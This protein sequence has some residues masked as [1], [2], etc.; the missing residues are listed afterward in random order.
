V[1]LL[2]TVD[3]VFTVSSRGTVVL[4][5][6]L[7]EAPARSDKVQLKPPGGQV[8]DSEIRAIEL[9]KKIEGPCQEAFLLP[10][11]MPLSVLPVGT[12]MW[13]V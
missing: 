5:N 4:I 9:I 2:G 13:L 10:G 12:E 6:R 7:S 8:I 11:H 3:S 1:T